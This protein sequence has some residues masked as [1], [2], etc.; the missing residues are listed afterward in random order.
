MQRSIHN[1]HLI[2]LVFS[3]TNPYTH[4]LTRTLSLFCQYINTLT[5]KTLNLLS[6]LTYTHSLTF[7]HTHPPSPS[8]LRLPL[9]ILPLSL[10]FFLRP[11]RLR[12]RR[13]WVHSEPTTCSRASER[14]LQEGRGGKDRWTSAM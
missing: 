13:R 7:T 10:S 2:R 11:Q 3:R 6:A 12:R 9:S 8:L 5:L 1:L 14:K 4:T